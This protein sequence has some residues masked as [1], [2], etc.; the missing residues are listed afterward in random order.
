MVK[1]SFVLVCFNN[2]VMTKTAINS[3]NLSVRGIKDE[4]EL[5]IVN[6]GS[7]DE[8]KEELRLWKESYDGPLHIVIHSIEKNM[9]YIVGLNT[10]IARSSGEYIAVLNNDLIFLPGWLEALTEVLISDKTIGVAAP[11]L[12]NA[13]GFQHLGVFLSSI[14]D[15]VCYG[16]EYM[17]NAKKEISF[18]YR[19]VSACLLIKREVFDKIGGYD[20]WF[21][22]G[23]YDDDDWCLRTT[24]AGYKIAI[25]K[26]SFVYHLG[27]VT[28][29]QDNEAL[30]AAYEV[31]RLKYVRKWKLDEAGRGDYRNLFAQEQYELSKHYAPFTGE[32]Y[33]ELAKNEEVEDTLDKKGQGAYCIIADFHNPKSK[34]KDTVMKLWKNPESVHQIT[35]MVPPNYFDCDSVK[36]MIDE[37]LSL[38]NE[39]SV[40]QIKLQYDFDMFTPQTF[41]LSMKK[42]GTV[43]EIDGDFVNHYGVNLA[44]EIENL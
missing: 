1:Y 40:S 16:L 8:T 35:F 4:M 19:V 30:Q 7:V 14:D 27:T 21:G 31:N 25:V 33:K 29:Y 2:W 28:F 10:G 11:M 17:K 15:I 26:H 41:Y 12:S 13:S 37:L 32:Q 23:M 39:E 38:Q 42:Y 3:L 43:V 20:F 5:I 9:G 34:W 24:I 18:V 44:R 22:L 36:K 6:N